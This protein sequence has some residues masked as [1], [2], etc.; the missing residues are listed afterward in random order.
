MLKK[1]SKVSA[2][3]KQQHRT[4]YFI[5]DL[6]IQQLFVSVL[7]PRVKANTELNNYNL[8]K[9]KTLIRGAN[10]IR[11]SLGYKLSINSEM[12]WY[13]SLG[14]CSHLF[15]YVLLFKNIFVPLKYEYIF[16]S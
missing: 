9:N 11:H 5:T 15:S 4:I 3:K 2:N 8:K 1:I 16:K 14:M 12:L 7:N 6:L 10:K 13:T